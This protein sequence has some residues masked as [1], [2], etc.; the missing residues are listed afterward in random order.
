MEY[1][2]LF[3]LLVAIVATLAWWNFS[4]RKDVA[5]TH[6]RTE[7]LLVDRARMEDYLETVGAMMVWLD[8]EGRIQHL[9]RR[10]LEVLGSSL[11]ALK[12]KDWYALFVPDEDRVPIRARF[13][14]LMSGAEGD[15]GY[16]EYVIVTADKKLRHTVWYRRVL[17]DENG[18]VSG[19]MSVGIDDT[20]RHHFVKA[21]ESYALHDELTGLYNLR[22][23]RDVSRQVVGLARRGHRR[24]LVV[25]ADVDNL[26]SIN[27]R[28]GHSV[29][30]EALAEAAQCLRNT[31]RSSDVIARVGGDEFVALT[32]LTDGDDPDVVLG[33]LRRRVNTRCAH[34]DSRYTLSLSLG[35]AEVDVDDPGGVDI[36]MVLADR[37]MYAQKRVH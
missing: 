1:G 10:S 8:I 34:A 9:N 16:A 17:R 7:Q 15:E 25:Y 29:G 2:A 5:S 30:D 12:G 19:L 37:S 26:K 35:V 28:L 18:D 36:A 22:G 24:T 13:A 4:L 11:E 31:L 27:D 14:S 6:L 23:F 32:T 3:A 20:E 21:L 33:N